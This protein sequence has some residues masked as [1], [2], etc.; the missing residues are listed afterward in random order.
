MNCSIFVSNVK[1]ANYTD[2]YT[3]HSTDKDFKNCTK[4]PLTRICCFIKVFNVE[5]I[6]ISNSK[7]EKWLGINIYC[8]LTFHNHVKSLPKKLSRKRNALSRVAY[9]LDFN[10]WK[11]LMIVFF[12]YHLSNNLAVCFLQSC[13]P[14]H[15]VN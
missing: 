5:G 9:Q 4:G 6:E 12:A 1:I 15:H 13:T 2:D 11:L 10:Q 8:K 14:N 3:P 7:C